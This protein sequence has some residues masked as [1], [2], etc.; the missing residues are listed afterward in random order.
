MLLVISSISREKLKDNNQ[1]VN[2]GDNLEETELNNFISKIYKFIIINLQVLSELIKI[3]EQTKWTK[4]EEISFFHKFLNFI[5]NKAATN[6]IQEFQIPSNQFRNKETRKNVE[7]T[8]GRMM[9]EFMKE[10]L[11]SSTTEATN[12]IFEE[13]N[14]HH[15]QK[16]GFQRTQII[17]RN[18]IKHLFAREPELQN[19]YKWI[20][21]LLTEPWCTLLDNLVHLYPSF[22]FIHFLK[23]TFQS[24]YTENQL[25]EL[26]VQDSLDK[27]IN[28]IRLNKIKFILPNGEQLSHGD[29]LLSLFNHLASLWNKFATMPRIF[30]CSFPFFVFL[31]SV[32]AFSFAEKSFLARFDCQEVNKNLRLESSITLNTKVLHLLP[33]S[34]EQSENYFISQLLSDAFQSAN[35]ILALDIFKSVLSNHDK[36]LKIELDKLFNF[37][38][39]N[40]I[41]ISKFSLDDFLLHHSINENNL[42]IADSFAKSQIFK[43]GA[44]FLVTDFQFSPEP[45]LFKSI[46]SAKYEDNILTTTKFYWKNQSLP[47]HI[48]EEIIKKLEQNRILPDT[49]EIFV[50]VLACSTSQKKFNSQSN[51]EVENELIT[52]QIQ[53]LQEKHF[54]SDEHQ[55]QLVI[56]SLS[57]VQSVLQVKHL[58]G[59]IRLIRGKLH[60]KLPFNGILLLE[61]YCTALP[62][63][64]LSGLH[65]DLRANHQFL[66]GLK[67]LGTII[68]N[69]YYAPSEDIP[70][71][72]RPESHLSDAIMAVVDDPVVIPAYLKMEHLANL[73]FYY[74]IRL[75]D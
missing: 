55:T 29:Q 48:Y 31:M 53:N 37:H 27:I 33:G 22:I 70:V 24:Q 72:L 19:S 62:S 15:E 65:S 35:S 68:K 66:N 5:H 36:S 16:W 67:D 26:S 21:L 10:S 12:K 43:F 40:F 1:L 64:E 3:T 47:P 20:N 38:E 75:V 25:L 51:N 44:Q 23:Q 6:P 8:L 57:E 32:F 63:S 4:V 13:A 58:V 18:S 49:K 42:F 61:Q 45:F 71:N 7:K 60:S 69:K 9:V 54:L 11:E 50:T 59:L 30:S 46:N 14:K 34:S 2:L 17:T 28:F 56:E 41:H 74:Q 73:L 52:K 39:R